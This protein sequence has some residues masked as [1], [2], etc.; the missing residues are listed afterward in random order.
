M[1]KC[2]SCP[3]ERLLTVSGK[4][5]DMFGAH[6]VK[7]DYN[8]YVPYGLNIGGGDYITFQYCLNCG[9]IQGKFPIT[10]EQVR[11]IFKVVDDD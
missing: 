3:S 5:S 10:E 6:D 2:I 4:V 8:G 1:S 9:T 7:I 11:E